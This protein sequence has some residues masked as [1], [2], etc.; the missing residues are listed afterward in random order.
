MLTAS[1]FDLAANRNTHT[2]LKHITA[3][4][5]TK[6]GLWHCQPLEADEMKQ[7]WRSAW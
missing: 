2:K 7:I 1:T 3:M 6:R 4:G 5:F